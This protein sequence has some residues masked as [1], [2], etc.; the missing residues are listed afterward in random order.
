MGKPQGQAR[1]IFRW[2]LCLGDDRPA[3]GVDV[4]DMNA[5]GCT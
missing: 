5:D 4:K 2:L 3:I 1:Y